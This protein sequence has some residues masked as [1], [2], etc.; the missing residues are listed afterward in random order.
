M[1]VR[2]NADADKASRTTNLPASN[3]ITVIMFVR[4]NT[5]TNN[6]AAFFS[7]DDASNFQILCT[8][9]DGTTLKVF[10]GFANEATGPSLTVGDW[11]AIGYSSNG[12]TLRIWTKNLTTNAAS[13]ENT[14]GARATNPVTG[15]WSMYVAGDGFSEAP[16][17]D[18]RSPMI[19]RTAFTKTQFDAQCASLSPVDS[20]NID[21]WF[22]W[23]DNSASAM[24]DDQSGNGRN[25]TRGAGSWTTE[26]DPPLGSSGTVAITTAVPSPTISGSPIITGSY[27][28]TIQVP[29]LVAEGDTSGSVSGDINITTTTPTLTANGSSIVDGATEISTI[30]PS[31]IGVGTPVTD[32]TIAISTAI[33]TL[34]APGTPYTSGSVSVE[35]IAILASSGSPVQTGGISVTVDEPTLQGGSSIAEGA[36]DGTFIE[37][38]A[39]ISGSPI[40][41]GSMS[42]S[43]PIATAAI[44]NYS[45]PSTMGGRNGVRMVTTSTSTKLVYNKT[46]VV[47]PTRGN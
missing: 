26:A 6:F 43:L 46:R 19:W 28:A 40:I 45:F 15:G 2:V 4:L 13:T 35:T 36:I 7:L 33:P 16:D 38:L 12:T 27:S 21:S 32:G 31:L 24:Q 29:T 25:L 18:F 14:G 8:D 17:A 37:P 20:T 39:S 34:I 23:A 3:N 42:A 1:S 9:G 41:T 47:D 30:A 44:V 5:D 10:D 22:T 11:Y